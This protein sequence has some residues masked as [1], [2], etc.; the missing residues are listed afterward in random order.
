[1]LKK[2]PSVARLLLASLLLL[3]PL[4]AHAQTR[5]KSPRN[6]FGVGTDLEAGR[7][8]ARRVESESRLLYDAEALAYVNRVGRDLVGAIPEQYRRREFVYAFRLLDDAEP[9]AAAV[10][11]GLIYVNRGLI[12]FARTE[13][14]L[15]GVLAHEIS[16]V[17]LR[18]S[19]AEASK[20]MLA[21]MGVAVLGGVL[22]DGGKSQAAQLGAQAGFELYLLKF[23]RDYETQ[24]DVLGAQI[25]ARAGYDPSGMANFFRRLEGEGGQP[26]RWLSTHPDPRSRA[27]RVTQEAAMLMTVP[28]WN[29]RT[30][31]LSRIQARLRGARDARSRRQNAFAWPAWAN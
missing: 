31:E 24:A 27:A 21:Q 19:T 25:M 26:P 28:R 16:H 9:N 11:G 6:L 17:A 29:F 7:E 22:G 1:M 2:A 15:A 4:A 30:S 12:E 8:L 18:H 3:A 5:V 20:K 14:E 13:G 23:S 10:P